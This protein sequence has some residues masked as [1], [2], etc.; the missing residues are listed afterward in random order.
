MPE[1]VLNEDTIK[2][3][4]FDLLDFGVFS[5]LYELKPAY[6]ILCSEKFQVASRGSSAWL[7]RTT[8]NLIK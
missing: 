4:T 2:N 6:L 7:E 1:L 3:G 5:M 8:H